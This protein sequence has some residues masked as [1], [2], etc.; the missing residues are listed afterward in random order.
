LGGWVGIV[1]NLMKLMKKL[2]SNDEEAM[3]DDL[4]RVVKRMENQ[5]RSV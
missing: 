4:V 1:L 5:T 2:V 3:N